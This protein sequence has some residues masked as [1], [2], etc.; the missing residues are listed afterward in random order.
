M[1]MQCL[2][3]AVSFHH[4]TGNADLG[5]YLV[6][7]DGRAASYRQRDAFPNQVADNILR[8]EV[9]VMG[10]L[11]FPGLNLYGKFAVVAGG[12]LVAAEAA[13]IKEKFLKSKMNGRYMLCVLAVH[14]FA[15]FL[16]FIVI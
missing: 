8:A 16:L 5:V 10:V 3:T 2:C 14:F 6:V 11:E 12:A 4:E 1:Q 15:L 7:P 9:I 13:V